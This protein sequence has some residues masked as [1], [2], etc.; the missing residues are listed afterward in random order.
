[1]RPSHIP[2]VLLV[3]ALL[4]GCPEDS[5]VD[6]DVVQDD[7]LADDDVGDD[8]DTGDDD[9]ADTLAPVTD[10]S[11]GLHPGI[12]TIIVVSWTQRVDAD[13]AWLEFT[14]ENDEWSGS[15]AEPRPAGQHSEVILGVPPYTDVRFRVVNEIGGERFD[16]DEH[17]STTGV[18]PAHLPQPTLVTWDP[19]LTSPE[20][21]LLGSAD[22]QSPEAYAGPFM[23][24]ILDRQGRVVWY[25][26]EPAGITS[27]S[28]RVAH[29][30]THIVVEEGTFYMFD[31]T[32]SY[33]RR[34]TPDLEYFEGVMAPNFVHSWDELGDGSIVYESLDEDDR[35]TM[36]RLFPDGSTEELWC[37]TDW[38]PTEIEI[39]WQCATNALN[40]QQDT[41]TA[42]WSFFTTSTV[43]EIDLATGTV[44]HQW[45]MMDDS[46]AFDPP[47]A[48]FLTQHWPEYTPDGNLLVFTHPPNDFYSSWAFEFV[49]D[50]GTET[51]VEVWNYGAG[52]DAWAAQQG[53]AVRLANGNT[54]L[55]YG[56][57]GDIREITHD[58]E[59]VWQ[60]QLP[61]D[62][63]VGH[64][65]L[66]ED[67]YALN[68]G[69]P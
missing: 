43:L 31:E 18:I 9:S 48:G 47:D 39:I 34:M 8:D 22:G 62:H 42:L 13:Q 24:F 61:V 41:D 67:L 11:A 15:P 23:L 30:G 69:T 29:D 44:L 40:W 52:V 59:V 19:D 37:C 33:I 64:T 10:I 25:F 54:L 51:L 63:M 35:Y 53:E 49:L 38:Y 57:Q 1:M 4:T 56:M 21:W 17:T 60:V 50:E 12:F 27:M 65:S 14:F 6:D 28:A 20:P 3:V 55:N 26:E 58:G 45:G 36:R 32:E 66:V 16:S 2:T 7:D 5:P 68:R 46:W